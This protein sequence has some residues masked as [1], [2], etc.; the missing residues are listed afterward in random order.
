MTGT[1]DLQ[2]RLAGTQATLRAYRS[3]I[4]FLPAADQAIIND[5]VEQ[6]L[7]AEAEDDQ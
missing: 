5:G 4:A 1:E 6:I 7:L 3:V 2:A